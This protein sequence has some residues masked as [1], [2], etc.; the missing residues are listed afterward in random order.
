MHWKI[1][2]T[3][4]VFVY[5]LFYLGSLDAWH[6]IDNANLVIHEAGHVVFSP[7]GYLITIAGGSLMQLIVP[8]VFVGYF[9]WKEN[10]YSASLLLYWLGI[11]FFNVSVYAGDAL[12][13]QLPLITGDTDSHDWNQILFYLGWL[14]HTE[15][16]S[17][18]I[19]ALGILCIFGALLW[20]IYSTRNYFDK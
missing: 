9:V 20:G 19:F 1:I 13:M 14:R 18:I 2:I 17:Y 4:C 10:P 3:V 11:N 15:T 16:I 8:A 7:F 6:F 12:R 5:C